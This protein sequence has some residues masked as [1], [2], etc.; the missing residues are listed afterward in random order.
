MAVPALWKENIIAFK[1][2]VSCY[3]INVRE[4]ECVAY[5]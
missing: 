3:E 5:M 1:A 4:V 2:L